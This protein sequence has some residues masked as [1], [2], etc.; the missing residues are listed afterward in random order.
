M[1]F[2]PTTTL[3]PGPNSMRVRSG[4]D[5]KPFSVIDF[6]YTAPSMLHRL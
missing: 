4:K 5:L 3:T 1:E 6:R 2:G